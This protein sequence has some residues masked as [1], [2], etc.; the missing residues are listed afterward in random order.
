MVTRTRSTQLTAGRAKLQVPGPQSRSTLAMVAEVAGVSPSTVSR[1]LNGT[2]RV[3]PD[4]TAAVLSAIDSLEFS[5]N[6]VA[7][8]LAGG[9]TAS[10]GVLTQT[11]SSPFYG[12]ALLG[13]EAALREES[14]IPLFVSG[15]WM[16]STERMAMDELMLRRVDGVI[17]LAGRLSD[18]MLQGYA[19]QVPMVVLG[20]SINSSRVRS[21]SFDNRN[22]A[23]LATRHLTEMGHQRIAYI[24]GDTDHDD[25]VER[26]EG[27]REGI[28]EAGLQIDPEL[29]TNGDF[30]EQ[31]GMLA[32]NRLLDSGV[33]F[34]AIACSN[35]QA[36]IG[37][38]LAL[39]R[40]NIRVPDDVSVVGFDD[41]MPARY[42]T[43]PLSS[44]QLSI[45]EAGKAAARVMLGLLR[46]ENRSE[47]L[48]E[49][50]LAIRESTQRLHR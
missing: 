9:R 3:S 24:V 16:E 37:A 45:Y 30:T 47:V 13:I 26:L 46:G 22:G 4:K 8:G 29:I 44:V 15:H 49:P 34:T 2:A 7:R 28:R 25:A 35:D 12:E 6:P 27:Y 41:V 14:Y 23:L 31:G 1:I 48:P 43:P 32:V 17:V 20:R 18:R 40:R 11:V 42:S 10:I 38:L 39:S 36:A 50:R 21:L 33:R 19:K 5:P